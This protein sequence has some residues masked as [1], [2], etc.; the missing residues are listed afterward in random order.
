MRVL[1]KLWQILFVCPCLS[2]S[3]FVCLSFC[4]S[5]PPPLYLSHFHS[6]S[7][8]Y[9]N[10]HTH[11]HTPESTRPSRRTSELDWRVNKPKDREHAALFPYFKGREKIWCQSSDRELERDTGALME[12]ERETFLNF[13]L[14]SML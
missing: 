6:F 2:I 12:G 1:I 13:N 14:P 10:T 8:S 7:L 9:T 11:K 3:V 5:L 4:L